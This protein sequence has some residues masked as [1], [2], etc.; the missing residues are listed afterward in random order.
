[1]WADAGREH[2]VRRRAMADTN[3]RPAQPRDL[4]SIKM[5]AVREPDPARHPSCR[6]KK[7]DGLQTVH[8]EAE[9]LFILGLAEMSVKLAVVTLCKLRAFAHEILGDRERR[10]GR[11]SDAN[12]RAWPRIMKQLQHPLAVGTDRLL[13]LHHSVRRQTAVLLR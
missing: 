13:V 9:A 4:V 5:N 1:G 8:F 7:I 11:E 3:F 6:F 10:T 2:H 12:V